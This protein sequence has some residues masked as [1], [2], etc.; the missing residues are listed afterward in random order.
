MSSSAASVLFRQFRELTDP[1]KGIPSFHIELENNNI[2]LWNV[3][4][5]VLNEDSI[6]HGG[7]FKAQ[8]KFPAEFPFQPP[9]FRF[10]PPIYHPNVYKDGKL[11]VSILHAAGDPTSEEPDAETWSP[12]QTVET[13][14][15]SIISL[16]ED[17]NINSPANVDAA[18]DWRKNRKAYNA[19]VKAEVERSKQ[20]IPPDF[21]M[22]TANTAYSGT[23]PP[24]EQNDTIDENFW[25]DSDQSYEEDSLME[26]FEEDD[27]EAEDEEDEDI[28]ENINSENK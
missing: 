9:S 14:L 16:L 22:P 1:K 26:D 4:V 25:Y 20:D 7:Y 17:P 27:E 21:I 12:V 6:Y 8:M 24:H 19:H 23:N 28:S 2:F 10:T 18:V 11:C 5:M 15:I 3:G 13:V